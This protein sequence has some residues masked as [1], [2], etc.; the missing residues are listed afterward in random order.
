MDAVAGE[1]S[2]ELSDGVLQLRVLLLQGCELDTQ[3]R[4]TLHQAL[5][6]RLQEADPCMGHLREGERKR[7]SEEKQGKRTRLFTRDT[8]VLFHRSSLPAW[9]QSDT[10]L[11]DPHFFR[12]KQQE[13]G[14]GRLS[15][16]EATIGY[17]HF[18]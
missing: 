4:L 1:Q 7:E 18:L 9:V 2:L 12:V 17:L 5:H 11:S 6:M 10:N 14:S 3:R 16:G 13:H 15:T 8:C